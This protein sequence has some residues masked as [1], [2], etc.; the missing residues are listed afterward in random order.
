MVTIDFHADGQGL[1]SP[2]GRF[3][4]A[5]SR[6]PC[7]QRGL[8]SVSVSSAVYGFYDGNIVLTERTS[9]TMPNGDRETR[10]LHFL[11]I[12]FAL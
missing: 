4:D 11:E 10:A 7:L 12:Y 1:P 8:G 2:P 3:T 5:G 9:G 6:P